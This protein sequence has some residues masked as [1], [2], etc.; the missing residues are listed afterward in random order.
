[1]AKSS[2]S[3]ATQRPA[4]KLPMW[5]LFRMF[6]RI[7]GPERNFYILA[8]IYGIGISLLSLAT[9]I[10]VQMLINTVANTGLAMPLVVLS[11]TLF[12][13][14]LISGL[15]NA[16]RIHLMEIF[17]RRFYAR[18]VAEITLRSIYAQNPFFNDASRGALFNRYFD[19]IGVQKAIPVLLIGGFTVIL[20]AAVGF[21]LV[22]LYHPLFLVFNLVLVGLVW[23]IWAVLGRSAIRSAIRLSHAKHNTAA[24]LETLGASNG[25]FKSEQRV[26]FALD[27]TDGYT[28]TYIDAHRRHFHRHFAQTLSY[29]FLY[30]AASAVLLGLGGWLVIQG[31]LTLGQ[32][33]AA[34]LVLSAAFFGVSQ[35]GIY[36][37]YFYD[38]CAAVEELNMFYEVEQEE[39]SGDDP[40]EGRDH[41]LVFNQKR[42]TARSGRVSLDM[43]LQ[44]GA[45][46]M[47]AAS[48]HGVQRL[49]TNLLK[50]HSQG[51]SG[52]I[53]LG[54]IDLLDL[55]VQSLRRNIYVID[56]ASFIGATIREYLGLSMR[57]G[58]SNRMMEALETVGLSP[59]IAAL[60]QGLDTE[61]ATTGWPLSTSEIMQL[62]LANA[63]MSQPKILVLNQLFDLIEDADFARAIT[64]LRHESDMTVIYFT[65][66]QVDLGFDKFMHFE[67]EKQ[68][69]FDSHDEFRRSV[70]DEKK[71]QL[72]SHLSAHSVRKTKADKD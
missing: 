35:L 70:L 61:I 17:A 2:H 10:S 64:Q 69:V 7:L 1:M 26:N 19:I 24:W 12:V 52:L 53:T 58:Q 65:H 55:N 50:R 30:A 28:G 67:A 32:L 68:H 49:F 11:V 27:N 72:T 34:E 42:G 15:L 45:T 59:V 33:V 8:I 9:P 40:I 44:S 37:N 21:V 6:L 18:M 43:T 25:F 31:Q 51:D 13:L 3:P 22:S 29:L 71:R 23:L 41:T 57:P 20:Q 38:L 54:G 56:R 36:L 48:D 46:V 47:A 5:Q 39:P 16:L 60:P 66:R 63:L 4:P 14:L 62:K